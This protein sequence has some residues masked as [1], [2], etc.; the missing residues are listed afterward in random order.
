MSGIKEE[1]TGATI[2]NQ[3]RLERAAHSGSFLLVEGADDCKLFEA[4]CDL[5][6]CSIVV[7]L[8]KENLIVALGIL[9]SASFQGAM[10]FADRDYSDIIGY[11]EHTGDLIY[12]DGNNVEIM[13]LS[14]PAIEN[15]MR[16]FGS[17]NKVS[18]AI[19][20]T[21]KTLAELIFEAAAPVGSLRFVS[22]REQWN[23]KFEDMNY[24]FCGNQ[25]YECNILEYTRHVLGRSD[26]QVEID[27]PDCVEMINQVLVEQTPAHSLCNG[28]DCVRVLGRALKSALGTTNQ[29]DSEKGAKTLSKIVRLAYEYEF[30]T[31]TL[32][33][34][35]FRDWESKTGY[36]VLR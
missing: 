30:F 15:V 35:G 6:Q 31:Q 11:P 29:F 20:N 21:V 16:E 34:R 36:Q 8:G 2:A 7:C 24:K 1:I 26:I 10:G 5:D 25:S 33:F 18:A 28:H 3:I 13:I 4:F 27:P 9:A 19:E 32:A 17:A 12:S 14:S 22:Q 23:L